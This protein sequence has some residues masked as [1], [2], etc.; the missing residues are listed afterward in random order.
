MN[1]TNEQKQD[2]RHVVREALVIR[3]P[4]AL[5]PHQVW[6]AAKKDLD[7]LFEESDVA[8]ALE[9]LRGLNQAS[10]KFDSLGSVPYWAATT[11]GI[12]AHERGI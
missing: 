12:Q 6:R 2:L 5:S 1:L 7:F 9:F 4:A 11:E 3:A 10:F 8:A